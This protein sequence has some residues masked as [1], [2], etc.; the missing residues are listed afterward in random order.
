MDY[1][2]MWEE[3]KAKIESDLEYYE[4]G[5]MCSMAESIH[6]GLYSQSMLNDMKTLEEKYSSL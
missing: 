4:D 1:K 3:L 6:G 5:K 2:A